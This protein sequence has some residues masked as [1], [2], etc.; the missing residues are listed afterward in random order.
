MEIHITGTPKE[1]AALVL[2]VQERQEPMDE[3]IPRLNKVK[4]ANGS[5]QAKDLSSEVLSEIAQ[6]VI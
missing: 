4:M 3:L 1:I 2:A 5:I 6:N